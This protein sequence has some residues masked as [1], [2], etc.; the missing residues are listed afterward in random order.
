[1]RD[2]IK[3]LRL[4]G[5][6]NLALA[7]ARTQPSMR[8]TLDNCTD[9]G[10]LVWYG[11]KTG[12]LPAVQSATLRSIMRCVTFVADRCGED[13]LDID[14]RA[15]R[16][17][18]CNS[19]VSDITRILDSANYAYDTSP[20]LYSAACNLL[21]HAWREYQEC[22]A[23]EDPDYIDVE[24]AFAEI[25]HAIHLTRGGAAEVSHRLTDLRELL[26]PKC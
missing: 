10:W 7:Y 3:H 12:Q 22:F 4:L 20:L 16:G 26:E 17:L 25:L 15:L 18:S 8:A 13:G 19:T 9:P 21:C 6:C 5:S 14:E 11:L 1:M 24:F 2:H 23:R